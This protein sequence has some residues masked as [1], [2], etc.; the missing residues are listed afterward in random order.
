[1]NAMAAQMEVGGGSREV[2]RDIYRRMFDEAKDDQIKELA[3]RRLLQLI[4][5]D[6]RDMIR[7]VLKDARTRDGACPSSWRDVTA[8]LRAKSLKLDQAGSPLDPLDVPYVLDSVDCDVKLHEK[9]E[10]PRK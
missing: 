3:A 2:A 7:S 5:L 9:S 1:M 8:Q 10:I 4:S 6:Q